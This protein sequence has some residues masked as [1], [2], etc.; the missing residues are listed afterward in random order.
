[1]RPG[2]STK[3]FIAHLSY[4]QEIGTRRPRLYILAY[5][6]GRQAAGVSVPIGIQLPGTEVLIHKPFLQAP[7]VHVNLARGKHV[8]CLYHLPAAVNGASASASILKVYTPIALGKIRSFCFE[9]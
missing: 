9:C 4:Q 2:K 1:M 7:P 8:S 6:K 3:L 5:G